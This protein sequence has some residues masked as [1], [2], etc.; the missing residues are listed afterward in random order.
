[1]NNMLFS[2]FWSRVLYIKFNKLK[3]S[4]P[5]NTIKAKKNLG[6]CLHSKVSASRFQPK[7]TGSYNKNWVLKFIFL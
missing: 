2:I 4:I 6:P 1:M 3:S 7:T 5:Q